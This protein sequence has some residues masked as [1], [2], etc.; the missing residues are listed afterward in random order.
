MT[1]PRVHPLEVPFVWF[2]VNLVELALLVV[3]ARTLLPEGLPAW[4]AV[5]LWVAALAGVW[6]LNYAIRRRF[7]PH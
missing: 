3:A 6:S 4:A 7:L 2:V 5:A 1:A